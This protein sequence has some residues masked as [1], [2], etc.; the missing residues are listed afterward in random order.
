MK[1]TSRTSAEQ[2]MKEEHHDKCVVYKR[3]E[4]KII[5][6]YQKTNQYAQLVKHH[7]NQNLDTQS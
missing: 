3:D 7:P 4:S 2:W 5:D 6:C 1:I